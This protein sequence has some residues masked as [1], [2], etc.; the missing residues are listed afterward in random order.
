MSDVRARPPAS[1]LSAP[2]VR[3]VYD[4]ASH[5]AVTFTHQLV[6]DWHLLVI[7]GDLTVDQGAPLTAVLQPMIA[8]GVRRL[9]I[10]LARTTAIDETAIHEIAGLDRSLRREGGELRLVV[11]GVA[12]LQAMRAAG[13]SG[14]FEIHRYVGDIIGAVAGLDEGGRGR[15]RSGLV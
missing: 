14:H 13:L 4:S 15:R 1:N 10:D 6:R 11:D 7:R 9:I 12:V 3:V 8:A 2:G 5:Q